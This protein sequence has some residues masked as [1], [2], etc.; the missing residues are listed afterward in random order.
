MG[1]FSRGTRLLAAAFAAIATLSSVDAAPY[2]ATYDAW[3][4]N[5]N[6]GTTDPLQY[7]TTRANTTYHPSPPNWRA[8]PF[9]TILLDKFADGDPSNNNF[10]N[11][12]FEHDWRETQMRFG[13]DVRGLESK[14]D[15]LQGM[16][17]GTIYIA[18]TVFLNMPWQADSYS[19]LDFTTLDPHWGT[20]ED[21]VAFI[22]GVHA[23]GMYIMLDFT[24]GTMGD[25]I[26]FKGYVIS[27]SSLFFKIKHQR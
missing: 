10:F 8:L 6:Q 18:G 14:L 17:I 1:C 2:N 4:L 16:G 11:I 7:T 3:N 20:I 5:K 26:A 24:V 23:R 13:G 21:W 19:P 25:M 27:I 15:Y 12:M 9:Y 22:D